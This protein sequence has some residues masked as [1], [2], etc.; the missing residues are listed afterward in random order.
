MRYVYIVLGLFISLAAAQGTPEKPKIEIPLWTLLLNANDSYELPYRLRTT[1]D[2]ISKKVDQSGL[3]DLRLIGSAQFST[4]QFKAVLDYMSQFGVDPNQ[5]VVVDL[6]EEPHGFVNGHAFRWYA[7]GAWW[8]Q[9]NPVSLVLKEEKERLQTLKVGQPI[10][11]KSIVSKDARGRIEGL[12]EHSFTIDTLQT[13]EQVVAAAGAHYVRLPVTD[14]MRP[15]D[16]D[17]DQFLD[18]VKGLPAHACLYV[19]CHAGRGRTS[20]F[21]IM[22]DMI[23]NPKLSKDAII[24]R[25][26]KL[27]SLDVRKLS[28]PLKYHK[29]PNEAFRLLFINQFYEYIHAPDG[30]GK[31]SWTKWVMKKNAQRGEFYEKDI[32]YRNSRV[33]SPAQ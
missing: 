29:H 9:S 32:P 1:W 4:S 13:E 24:D 5:I 18:L 15:E 19:H 6:R 33:A 23:R 22:Y 25:Q 3:P 21:M 2:K 27:G 20:T 12:K 7:M 10:T 31:V 30:Y 11:L 17:V 8:T 16:K 14:H 28:G 26:V